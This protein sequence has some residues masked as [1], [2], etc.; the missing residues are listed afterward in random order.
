MK[1]NWNYIKTFLL[2]GVVFF[3]FAFAEKRNHNRVLSEVNL[4]FTNSEN[5]YL[6]EEAV[7]KLLIQNEVKVSSIGKETLDLNRVETLLEAHDMI[8]NAEVF[9]TVDGK[10]GA[11]ITQRK[12]L[13]RVMGR[14]PYYMDRNGL[15]M[16][17]SQYYS[18]RVPIVTGVSEDLLPEVHPLVS[19]IRNDEFLTKHVTELNRLSNGK[20]VIRLRQ[21]DFVVLF[22]AVSEIETK[23]MNFKAFYQKAMKDKKLNAY[24]KVDLQFGDQVVCTKK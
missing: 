11:A 24:K 21:L 10:M 3:L 14:A 5:L 17:L 12:P 16:P 6:T 7:N 18:A 9:M 23:F 4:H 13:A 19:Y 15:K 2:I 8:E 20:Y 22:G 1:I